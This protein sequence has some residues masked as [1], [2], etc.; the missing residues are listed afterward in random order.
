[1][2][3]RQQDNRYLVV[4]QYFQLISEQPTPPTTA[5]NTVLATSEALVTTVPKDV[6]LIIGMYSDGRDV[7][8]IAS[9]CKYLSQIFSSSEQEVFI[10]TFLLIIFE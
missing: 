1:M 8:S 6:W 3:K 9:T 7:A 4:P 2:T 10:F 5:I